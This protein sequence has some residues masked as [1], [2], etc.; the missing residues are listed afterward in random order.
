MKEK[1][2]KAEINEYKTEKEKRKKST[3]PKVS[4]LRTLITLMNSR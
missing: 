2:V 4:S 1:N 3:R